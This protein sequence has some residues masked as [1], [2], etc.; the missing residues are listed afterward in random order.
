MAIV[1]KQLTESR[2]KENPTL[3]F[4]D[5]TIFQ[6]NFGRDKNVPLTHDLM[7]FHDVKANIKDGNNVL[8]NF[9]KTPHEMNIPKESPVPLQNYKVD[10]MKPIKIENAFSNMIVKSDVQPFNHKNPQIYEYKLDK[11]DVKD[12]AIKQWEI[13]E[14]QTNDLSRLRANREFMRQYN[15]QQSVIDIGPPGPPPVEPEDIDYSGRR[16]LEGGREPAGGGEPVGRR[17][18]GR[19][20]RAKRIAGLPVLSALP[21]V[22][23]RQ[24]LKEYLASQGANYNLHPP[25]DR[26]SQVSESESESE[27]R[28]SRR[29][30]R[31]RSRSRSNSGSIQ[32]KTLDPRMMSLS[33]VPPGWTSESETKSSKPQT[34]IHKIPT[35]FESGFESD[36]EGNS[37]DRKRNTTMIKK[38][39]QKMKQ[40]LQKIS[41]NRQ[42]LLSSATLRPPMPPSSAMETP[43]IAEGKPRRS[44]RFVPPPPSAA[45]E[46]PVIAEDKPQKSAKLAHPPMPPNTERTLQQ[47]ERDANIRANFDKELKFLDEA[48]G[49]KDFEQLRGNDKVI[50]PNLIAYFGVRWG[51][52]FQQTSSYNTVYEYARK[53]KF[54]KPIR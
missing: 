22:L 38:R 45:M 48:Y 53:H 14:G 21:P 24:S 40:N 4:L 41:E 36:S 19:A 11:Y 28:T 50:T 30:A 34:P 16:P 42:A 33:S 31:T 1:I 37:S 12:L 32:S 46:T 27:F 10:T 13:S 35:S 47:Q 23:P 25:Q 52:K 39:S 54:Y 5:N 17:G 29:S 8:S 44:V 2:L 20:A 9:F 43:V 51:H 18:G 49:I 7:K 26:P 6:F 3:N 15:D